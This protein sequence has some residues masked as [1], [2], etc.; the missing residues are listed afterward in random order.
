MPLEWTDE[1][2]VLGRETGGEA[3]WRTD[4]LGLATGRLVIWQRAGTARRGQALAQLDLFD[5]AEVVASRR[6]PHAPRFLREV[7]PH[8]SAKAQLVA[9]YRAF[10]AG[11]LWN[12]WLCRNLP[13]E[14][15]VPELHS[16]TRQTWQALNL[17]HLPALVLLKALFRWARDEGHPVGADWLPRL[18]TNTRAATTIWLSRPLAEAQ[19]DEAEVQASL[20]TLRS[21]L[22]AHAEW[23]L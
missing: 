23:Q 13:I 12:R 3:T 7:I 11:A 14:H 22:Q 9:N 15:P 10:Q 6:D 19:A 1:V 8:P 18:P 21:Y 5:D 16:L 17:G 2:L 4:C 20:D